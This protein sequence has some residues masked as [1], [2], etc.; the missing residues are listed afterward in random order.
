MIAMKPYS[1]FIESCRYVVTHVYYLKRHALELIAFSLLFIAT[2][3]SWAI[4]KPEAISIAEK[5]A[6]CN[7][8][9]PCL[10]RA[11]LLKGNWSIIV[12]FIYGR[13]DNGEPIMVPGGWVGYT[14]Y[15]DGKIIDKMPG[16]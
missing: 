2:V 1:R 9:K 13:R 7:E 14:I 16:V 15:Q 6:G 4:E 11:R 3:S 12:S 8:Q 10:T 5:A